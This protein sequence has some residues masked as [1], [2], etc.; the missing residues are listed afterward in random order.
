MS[1]KSYPNADLSNDGWAAHG[2][3][4]LFECLNEHQP[5]DAD[6]VESGTADSADEFVVQLENVVPVLVPPRTLTVR[7]KKEGTGTKKVK[8]D[9]L[10]A[11]GIKATGVVIPGDDYADYAFPI[12]N[13][14]SD[15]T[16]LSVRITAGEDLC[17]TTSPSTTQQGPM[18]ASNMTCKC[19][20]NGSLNG[21]YNFG[22]FSSGFGVWYWDG[23]LG[24]QC[25][26]FHYP[27]FPD[28]Y[29]SMHV[30]IGCLENGKWQVSASIYINVDPNDQNAGARFFT[31]SQEFDAIC[32]SVKNGRFSGLVNLNLKDENGDPKSPLTLEWR[33]AS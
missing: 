3:S 19:L 23:N 1:Q 10:D 16:Q 31:D 22:G 11:E 24:D 5:N 15:W 4:G 32:L 25:V 28:T 20:Q 30:T 29:G 17:G 6:Y 8:V 13:F 9:F 26:V 27:P 18:I 33:D 2:A 14:I 12:T 7:M 21:S